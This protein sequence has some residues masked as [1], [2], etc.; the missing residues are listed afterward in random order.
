MNFNLADLFESI[1]DAVPERTALVCGEQRRTFAQLDRRANQCAHALAARGVKAGD[2]VGLY[3]MNGAEYLE[4]MIGCF[5][6]RAVPVNVNFRYVEDELHYLLD[7]AGA[8]AVIHQR[9]FA[10]RLAAVRD[11]LPQLR[12]LLSV[13]D[14]SGVDLTGFRLGGLRVGARRRRTRARLRGAFAGRSLHH[15]HRRHHG[16]AEGR[17]VAAGRH[18]LFRHARREPDRPAAR[19][20][21]GS[22]RTRR[23]GYTERGHDGGAA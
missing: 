13:D 8:V 1:A 22:G 14:G 16:H 2:V 4:A 9:S 20:T 3:L 6:M 17:D 11:R 12:T 7:D 10:P 23:C 5:K 15:L 18:L 21:R 19:A